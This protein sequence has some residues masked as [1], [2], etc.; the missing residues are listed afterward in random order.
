MKTRKITFAIALTA[1]MMFMLTAI[2]TQ[3]QIHFQ[4]LVSQGEGSAIWNADGSGPEL[5]A[6]GHPIP[7][8]GFE[9]QGY[10]YAT[11]DYIKSQSAL[12]DLPTPY[13]GFHLQGPVSGFPLFTQSL[14]D[15]GISL[16]QIN[17]KIRISTLGKDLKGEDWLILNDKHY[18]NYYDL[19]FV[20]EIKGEPMIKGVISY[21]NISESSNEKSLFAEYSFTGP[22]DASSSSSDKVQEVANAFLQD[23][24]GE[25]MHITHYMTYAKSLTGNGRT[26]AYYNITKGTIDKGSPGIPIQGLAKNH[27][28]YAVWNADGTGPEPSMTGHNNTPYYQ[29]SRDYDNLDSDPNAALCSFLKNSNGFTNFY[30]Q[31]AYRGYKPG[32]VRIKTNAQN[33]DEDIMGEDWVILNGIHRFNYYNSSAIIELDGNPLLGFIEDTTKFLY[34]S[35]TL[36]ATSSACIVYDARG[37]DSYVMRAITQAFL[38][39]LGLRQLQVEMEAMKAPGTF[40]GS[41]RVGS[42]CEITSGKISAMKRNCTKV[43]QGQISGHWK[44]S[45]G[46][47][48]ITGDITI[49]E[50]KTLQIEPGAWL[51]F[52]EGSTISVKG[53]IEA[54]GDDSNTG[55]IVFT[56][57][58]PKNGWGGIR[59]VNTSQANNPSEFVNCI[60]I[61]GNAAGEEP[62]NSGGAIAVKNYDDL[63]IE[64]C[65]FINNTAVKSGLTYPPSGGAIALWGS[66]PK[67]INST[68]INNKAEYGGAIILYNGSNAR[69]EHNLFFDN[70]ANTSGGA[71]EIA[72]NCNPILL[73]NT[74]TRNK[75]EIGG[76]IDISDNSKPT[77]IN[78]IVC[79]NS[80]NQWYQIS[81]STSDCKISTTYSDIEKGLSN[82]GPYPY[83]GLYM[84]NI[85]KSP[86]F[87]NELANDFHLTQNSAC[88]NTGTPVVVDPNGTISDMGAF[89][90]AAPASPIARIATD[91]TYYSFQ[92]NW[93]PAF[94]AE[95]YKLYVA[96]DEEFM[97]Y[98]TGYDGLIVSENTSCFVD[99]LKDNTVYYYRLTAL[100]DVGYSD[101]SNIISLKTPLPSVEKFAV[102][103]VA[104][105]QVNS[106]LVVTIPGEVQANSEIYIYNITGQL[107]Q[108]Q[109]LNSGANNISLKQDHRILIVKV[110][111]NNKCDTR[112]IFQW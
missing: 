13:T 81:I 10:Y 100:N 85:S 30:L 105:R 29:A 64:N 97:D 102:S 8:P 47:Y 42:F 49:P 7:F 99:G 82:I 76:G 89:Y 75:S 31:L 62:Y 11:R 5:A 65:L 17:V 56:S 74:I 40:I 36:Y 92:A 12:A 112:K 103:E 67:I 52:M 101:F 71:I 57:V 109:S 23:L 66:S 107:L 95:Y 2:T 53:N 50:G 19:K 35:G 94:D 44:A 27:Q 54:V 58:N 6:T 51:K 43:S 80:A 20:F 46:P 32:Q 108:H 91:I 83:Q 104:L 70:E 60:F 48:I 39:D 26:G 28:G 21:A 110:I 34:K 37:D 55:G 84:N 90:F 72:N 14:L 59:F 22:V 96:Y 25:E 69:I 3:S 86:L 15:N 24:A 79:G 18:T 78:T 98:V 106:G 61:N 38:K 111:C 87:L 41:G 45:E 63:L 88:V 77:I 1:V 68:F 4:G 33:M 93:M 73:N 9:N 16:K